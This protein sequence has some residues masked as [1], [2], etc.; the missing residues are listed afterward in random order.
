MAGGQIF[1]MIRFLA[2]RTIRAKVL[3][4]PMGLTLLLLALGGYAYTLLNG[5]ETSVRR[6]NEAVTE[7]TII[8]LEFS[9]RARASLSELYRLTSVAANENDDAKLA[10]LSKDETERLESFGRAFGGLKASLIAAGTTP[11]QVQALD[12]TLGDYIKQAK[13]VA[14][15][16]ESDA[17]SALTFMSGTQ[18]KFAAM[19]K[20]LGTVIATLANARQISLA[21]IYHDMRTGRSVFI[22]VI[23]ATAVAA[24]MVAVL[25]GRLISRPVIAMTAVLGRLADKDYSAAIPALGQ[26]NEIGHMAKAIEILKDRSQEADRL[27][28]ERRQAAE[29]SLRNAQ[30][31]Q[32]ITQRFECTVGEVAEHV[33]TSAAAMQAKAELVA[34]A[35]AQT[36]RQCEAVNAASGKATNNTQMVAAAAE[37]LS[38]SAAEVSRQVAQATQIAGQAVRE[39]IAT[40]ASIQELAEAGQKINEVV[41]LINDIAGQTNLLALNATIEAARA[42]EA[43]KG[44]AVVASEVKSLATQTAKATEDIATQVT[45]IQSATSGA[46]QAIQRISDTIGSINEIATAIASAVEQ[47]GAASKEIACNV[48]EAA[49][50]TQEVSGDIVEVTQAAAKTG[51]A[52][53]SLIDIAGRL[54]QQS[55][56]LR[57]ELK[58][59]LSAVAA[60]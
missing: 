47:Q 17:A 15:M 23:L 10:K 1:T 52:S 31:L 60:A 16:A 41:K 14:D 30:H 46:V 44:F 21:S 18:T 42:G 26:M 32:G 57:Q 3:A 40:D 4:V 39:A 45:A 53:A 20:E 12:A 35:A 56:T 50:C 19:E 37:E 43:G 2:D 34:G 5:N 27:V 6:L 54:A 59:F 11:S 8:V 22:S 49:T 28:E 48:Q 38:S 7:P 9:A 58:S 24:L 29:A 36:S 55:D 51:Q 33:A 25:V 13:F